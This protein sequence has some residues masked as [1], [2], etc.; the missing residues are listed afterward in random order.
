MRRAA[1]AERGA[2]DDPA[3][4]ANI[5]GLRHVRD[6]GPGITRRRAG[7]AFRYLGPDGRPV[8]DARTLARIRALAIP[9]AWTG[10]WICPA[11]NGHI[12][13]TGHDARGRKQY[14]YHARWR[15]VRD[16]TKYGR[17]LAFIRALP[18]IRKRVDAD[19]SLPGLPRDKVLAAVVWLL[20]TTFV[21]VGNEEYARDNGSFGLTT[22][23]N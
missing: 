4:A 3:G 15:E 7:A 14:R 6:D 16:E 21:R 22:L 18:A 2:E 10:V 12:Q 5:V 8:R 1:L 20:E 11:E 17:T 23:R 9:P 19:L 13:A